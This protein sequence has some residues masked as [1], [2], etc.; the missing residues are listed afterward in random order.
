MRDVALSGL[1]LILKIKVFRISP[2]KNANILVRSILAD[3]EVRKGFWNAQVFILGFIPILASLGAAGAT[4]A[5]VMK[6]NLE[7]DLHHIELARIIFGCGIALFLWS[8]LMVSK[9]LI[10]PV[11]YEPARKVV[12][13]M[14]LVGGFLV[15]AIHLLCIDL[16]LIYVFLGTFV[17]L[18]LIVVK[19][20]KAWFSVEL[21]TVSRDS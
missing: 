16:D 4:F 10:Y 19:L 13:P 3:R 2:G 17:V 7:S 6:A 14:M 12:Q 5:V 18:M 15:L 11:Q 21:E 9:M 8:V 1:A 20:V